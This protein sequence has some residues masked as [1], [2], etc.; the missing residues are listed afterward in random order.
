[1]NDAD[2]IGRLDSGEARASAEIAETAPAR[3]VRGKAIPAE[4]ENGL[5]TQSWFPICLATDVERGRIKGYD[6]LDGRVVVFRSADGTPHVL[7]AYCP[8]LG[9]DLSVGDVLD[10]TIR[11]AF[12]H[13]CYEATGRCVRTGVGDR[14]PPAARLFRFPTVEK[15]G[16][17]FAFNGDEPSWA[18]PDFPLPAEELAY[19]VLEIPET[20]PVDPWMICCNTPDL[21]HIRALH[22]IT[23][24]G[25]DPHDVVEWTNHSMMYD[26]S[27]LH[28]GGEKVSNRVGIFGTSVY[29]QVTMLEGRWF[30][31]LAPLGLPRPGVSRVF[32]AVAARRDDGP[33][34][35]V[36]AFLDR[37]V[38]L[39]TS[40]VAEDLPVMKTI[41]FR[42]GTLTRSDRTLARFFEYLRDFPR[43]HPA[44]EFIR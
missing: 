12:H 35:D 1:M 26:F 42:P 21:Q 41:R 27:G 37:V 14:P 22:G 34:E 28:R 5:F 11:C 38:A 6:F 8:H 17:V 31:F 30:A 40:I 43:A 33:R 18:V 29:Y 25:A 19:R 9:A 23:F 10:D 15:H 16:I 7:S 32:M 20:L 39:E 24:D 13:W 44:A 3:P 4:G 2:R 36:E